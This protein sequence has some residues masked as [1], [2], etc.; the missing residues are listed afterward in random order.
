MKLYARS[1]VAAFSVG[2]RS[3]PV[4]PDGAIEIDHAADAQHLIENGQVVREAPVRAHRCVSCKAL[5]EEL[6]DRIAEMT[7]AVA[8]IAQL[9]ADLAAVTS[10]RDEALA[11]SN[12]SKLAIKELRCCRHAAMAQ[13]VMAGDAIDPVAACDT[14]DAQIATLTADRDDLAKKLAAAEDAF[15]EHLDAQVA[16]EEKQSTIAKAEA[17]AAESDAK[18]PE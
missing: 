15:A 6:V 13:M 9:R 18:K 2:G 1:G 7:L 12:A 16:A 14:K 10:E 4:G 8:A 17:P 11:S 5:G 3:Y